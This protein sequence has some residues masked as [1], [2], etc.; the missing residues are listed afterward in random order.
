M[1]RSRPTA[2]PLAL[3]VFALACAA[4]GCSGAESGSRTLLLAHVLPPEHAVHRALVRMG[5]TLDRETQGSLRLQIRHSAQLGAEKELLEKV[6]AG[7]IQLT[8]VST[9]A[10]DSLVPELG[11]FALPWLFRDHAHFVAATE[12]PLGRE[13]LRAADRVGL[14]ALVYYEAGARSFYSREPITGLESLRGLRVRVQQSPTMIATLAAL[15]A[16]PVPIPF[17][18]ELTLALKKGER[19]SAAENNPP[20]YWTE[21]HYRSAP[22]YFLDGHTR[23]PD[24]LLMNGAA[25]QALSES[26]RAALLGAAQESATWQRETWYAE[27][28][29][30]L[31][32]LEDGGV[33][34]TREVDT[35][36]FIA[37]TQPVYAELP[38]DL[39]RWSERIRALP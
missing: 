19:V 27:E 17:G 31:R 4:I 13:L 35:Q 6:Q 21:E 30:L 32:R 20:S 14:R 18:P 38:D 15:G 9:N 24:L 2:I 26:E 16:I 7:Q 1:R 8:K 39:R 12:G 10:L 3:L 37:A 25:W 29:A 33:K 11:V 5:E 36:P 22:Y 28:E 23:A 34:I